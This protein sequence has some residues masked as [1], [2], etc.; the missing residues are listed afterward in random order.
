[1][2]HTWLQLEARLSDC[3]SVQMHTKC[4]VCSEYSRGS[5][6]GHADLS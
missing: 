6:L 5:A 2:T 4:L 1:M 3:G